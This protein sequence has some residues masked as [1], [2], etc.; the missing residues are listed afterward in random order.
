MKKNKFLFIL[1]FIVLFGTQLYGSQA[2][3]SMV[4]PGW[5]QNILGHKDIAK[6]F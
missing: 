3:K 4:L 2:W 5:G 1:P 6:I